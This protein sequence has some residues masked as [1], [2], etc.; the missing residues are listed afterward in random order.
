MDLTSRRGLQILCSMGKSRFGDRYVTCVIEVLKSQPFMFTM[1]PSTVHSER[2]RM[3][4]FVY[5]KTYIQNSAQ[6]TSILDTI[7]L[8]RLVPKA[9]VWSHKESAVDLHS[10]TQALSMD[11]TSSFLCG[12]DAGSNFVEDISTRDSYLRAFKESLDGVFW[13]EYPRIAKWA[14]RLGIHLVPDRVHKSQSIIEELCSGMCHSAH[15]RMLEHCNDAAALDWPVVYAH[16]R[17]KLE[18]Q[19][20]DQ[21]KVDLLMAA[22]MLDHMI[23]GNDGAGNT[24]SFLAWQLS[25][26][27][28]IQR[29]L[30]K[31]LA[32]IQ[33]N[34]A[35]AQTL[36]GLS[37]V[38][39]VLM[40]TMRLHPAGLGPHLRVVPEKGTRL[41]PYSNIPGGTTVS[42]TAWALHRNE[43]VYF[44]PE[45][46]RPSRWADDSKR[47]EMRKWFFGFGAGNRTCIG[48]YLAIRSK[49][50][51]PLHTQAI[52]DYQ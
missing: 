17:P 32:T 28:E 8:K 44:E 1:L 4:S 3:I 31:E 38:D 24:L 29:Q 14:G 47:A 42:A 30:R 11:L 7:L 5:S 27:P 49:P 6:L 41:G 40:E 20:P 12:L 43:E 9:K 46:W 22:E 21:H 50:D 18:K 13:H 45:E 48:N 35:Y 16:L 37:L 36:D 23:A 33:E 19:Y 15:K 10:E 52:A 51:A 26:H 39:A 25:K 34:E 2:K